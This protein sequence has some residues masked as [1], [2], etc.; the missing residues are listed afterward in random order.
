[1]AL[2]VSAALAQAQPTYRLTLIKRGTFT[3][4]ADL[5]DRG[6]LVGGYSNDYERPFLWQNGV[7]TDLGSLS[8]IMEE[9]AA[10]A[11]I[12][13][14]GDIVGTSVKQGTNGLRPVLW[15][16]G[17]ITE[18]A[19]L[20]GHII[21]LPRDINDRGQIIGDTYDSTGR[22]FPYL[23][24]G[25][26]I[27]LLDEPPNTVQ[28]AVTGINRFG[29]ICGLADL[30]DGTRHSLLW[31]DGTVQDL[32]TLP[33]TEGSEPRDLNDFGQVVGTTYS[34]GNQVTAFLWKDGQ[35]VQLPKLLASDWTQANEINNRREIVGNSVDSGSLEYTATYWASSGTVHNLNT[36]VAADDPLKQYV[37]LVEGQSIN[38]RG[39]IIAAGED[40]RD[41]WGNRDQYLL[42]PVY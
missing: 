38:D 3:H 22:L 21:T 4:V 27:T 41:P 15:R 16:H 24:E 37:R 25:R 29:L 7:M 39:W 35:M 11:G 1:M 33:G 12:N 26:R 9:D 30:A 10:A 31:Q 42:R 17:R 32:G 40:S 36:L 13:A 2:C 18:L 34:G 6:Q 19:T 28:A 8:G 23:Q 14:F 5:N 20:P